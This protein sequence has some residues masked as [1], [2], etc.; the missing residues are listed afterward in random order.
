M[1]LLNSNIEERNGPLPFVTVPCDR[2]PGGRAP[3]RDLSLADRQ[4]DHV[5]RR[6]LL[7][8]PLARVVAEIAF[9]GVE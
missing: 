5:A 6:L 8:K 9:G 2:R 3:E 1:T 4:T 7:P